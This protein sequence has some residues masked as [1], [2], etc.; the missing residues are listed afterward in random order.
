MDALISNVEDF[1][2]SYDEQVLTKA[3]QTR[4]IIF[5]ILPDI[6]EQIDMPAKMIAYCYGQ[7]YS[8]LICAIIPSKKGLKLSFNHGSVLPDPFHVLE[9]NGKITRYIEIKSDNQHLEA[10]KQLLH[11]AYKA[12]QKRVLKN[13]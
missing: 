5:E 7:K 6:K 1:L 4:A 12:Y 9:G 10:L 8:E 2:A 3:L 11:D 13:K